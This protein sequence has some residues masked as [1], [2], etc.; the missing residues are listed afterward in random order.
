MADRDR[1]VGN[2]MGGGAGRRER[3][4]HGARASEESLTLARKRGRSPVDPCYYIPLNGSQFETGSQQRPHGWGAA[5]RGLRRGGG[6]S[7]VSAPLPGDQAGTRSSQR[8]GQGTRGV[9]REY[10]AAF[11]LRIR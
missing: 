9:P 7:R 5:G 11:S 6:F 8:G 3:S 10:A 2:V 1:S 4:G